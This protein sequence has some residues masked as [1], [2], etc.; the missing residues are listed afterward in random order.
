MPAGLELADDSEALARHRRI[1]P[2]PLSYTPILHPA[3]RSLRCYRDSIFPSR[4]DLILERLGS[5]R[6]KGR[7]LLDIGSGIGF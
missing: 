4:L 3:L 1:N 2:Y 7:T 5:W 6:V